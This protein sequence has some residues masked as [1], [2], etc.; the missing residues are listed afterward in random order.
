M[1]QTHP[2]A[3][4]HLADPALQ[5]NDAGR[6]F[7]FDFNANVRISELEGQVQCRQGLGHRDG[8]FSARFV[9]EEAG[10]RY[11]SLLAAELQDLQ[12]FLTEQELI[13]ILNTTASPVWEWLPGMTLA[14][15]VADDHGIESLDADTAV[16]R[17]VRKLA[18]LTPAQCLAVV[19]VC[20]QVWRRLGEQ[21]SIAHLAEDC[22]LTLA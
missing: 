16:V 7:I 17:L 11:F 8:A 10:W 12:G 20:E 5:S 22:G 4:A 21:S 13:V 9:L 15:V 19:D 18:K 1:Q 2:A 3:S 6:E 14:G